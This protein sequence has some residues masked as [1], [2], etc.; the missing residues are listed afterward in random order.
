MIRPHGTSGGLVAFDANVSGPAADYSRLYKELSR[1]LRDTPPDRLR[2]RR[3]DGSPFKATYQ[4]TSN[5]PIVGQS[6]FGELCL[7][8]QLM[9][10]LKSEIKSQANIVLP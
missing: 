10:S 8:Q 7:I 5:I 2:Q 9:R 1:R 3:E 6:N 4:Y